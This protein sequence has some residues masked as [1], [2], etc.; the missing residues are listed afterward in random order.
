M[1]SPYC[2][3]PAIPRDEFLFLLDSLILHA[4]QT[5]FNRKKSIQRRVSRLAVHDF[6]RHFEGKCKPG[7]SRPETRTTDR[8]LYCALRENSEEV[9]VRV[10]EA[11][12]IFRAEKMAAEDREMRQMQRRRKKQAR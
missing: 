6:N 2:T 9:K 4:R 8:M 7:S 3:H 11:I 5:G 10:D 1:G 12:T